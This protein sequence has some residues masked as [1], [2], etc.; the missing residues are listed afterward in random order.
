M[1][2]RSSLHS[3]PYAPA[4]TA[5]LAAAVFACAGVACSSS[6]STDDALG[7]GVAGGATGDAAGRERCASQDAGASTKDAAT[8]CP[9]AAA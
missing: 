3:W 5:M 7:G 9:T 1:A 4:V 6:V 2:P 8:R